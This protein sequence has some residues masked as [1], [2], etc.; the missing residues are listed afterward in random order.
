MESPLK[1]LAQRLGWFVLIWAI[2]VGRVGD[3]RLADPDG[4]AL[5]QEW[6]PDEDSNLD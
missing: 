1:P 3:R 4:T 2:S 5:A 6:M